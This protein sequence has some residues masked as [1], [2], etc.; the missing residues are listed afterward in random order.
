MKLNILF[1]K[2]HRPTTVENLCKIKDVAEEKA[3][4]YGSRFLDCIKEFGKDKSW[5]MDVVIEPV[6]DELSIVRNHPNVILYRS[7]ISHT[8][9]E[10][11]RI[12][13]YKISA[14]IHHH[15]H[16]FLK[17]PFPPRSGR[18]RCLSQIKSLHTSLKIAHSE[19]KPSSSMSSLTHRSLVF[20]PPP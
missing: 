16:L 9:S 19:C 10:S 15:H 17:H 6:S 4:K 11:I 5:K 3:I 1:R 2:F 14:W 7:S 12:C 18:V 20:L 13:I 8:R